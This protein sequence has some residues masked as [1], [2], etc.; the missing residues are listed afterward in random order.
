M[1]TRSITLPI[2]VTENIVY[3]KGIDRN[4]PLEWRSAD[5]VPVEWKLNEYAPVDP[6]PWPAVVLVPGSG[7]KA[8]WTEVLP[9]VPTM[10][11]EQ[12]VRV[13]AIDYPAYQPETAIKDKGR[14][15]REMADA[16]ACAVRFARA[17]ASASGNDDARVALVGFSLGGGIGSQVALA[18]ESIDSRWDAYAASGGGPAR[19][20][21][22]EVSKGS[23]RVDGLVGIAGAY[24][25]FLGTEGKYGREWMQQQDSDLW[26]MLKS[27]IDGNLSL[28]VR[29]LHSKKDDTIPYDNSLAFQAPLEAAGYD[30]KLIDVNGGHWVP[31]D[32][33]V[34]SVMNVLGN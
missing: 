30:V 29:L 1:P 5:N 20:V 6:G 13:Y 2:T 28:R 32:L 22:C 19:Q 26:K 31:P 18:G 21:G 4:N 33:V 12:G 25:A 16:V 11:A 24:D 17:R 7:G 8:D 15:Y 10:L 34:E 14:G 9:N 27:M 3:A 23:T